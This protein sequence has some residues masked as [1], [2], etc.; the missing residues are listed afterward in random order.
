[1]V[2]QCRANSVGVSSPWAEWGRS[3]ANRRAKFYRLT[4]EGNA[5]LGEQIAQWDQVASAVGR[6]ISAEWRTT[7]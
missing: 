1:M 3:E 6:V 7:A 4:P 2:V 5:R